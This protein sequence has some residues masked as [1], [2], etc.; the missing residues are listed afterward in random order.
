M[1][2]DFDVI[3][4]PSMAQ[5]RAPVPEQSNRSSNPTSGTSGELP[6]QPEP[7]DEKILERYPDRFVETV[8]P[9]QRKPT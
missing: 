8:R 3:T 9:S 2:H 1:S 7:A 6:A 4:G 5:R